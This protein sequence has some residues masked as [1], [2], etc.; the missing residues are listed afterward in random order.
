MTRSFV[1][2]VAVIGG[3]ALPA[4]AD[5]VAGMDKDGK[6]T[7]P[8]V[9]LELHASILSDAVDKALLSGAWGY[10]L[11][12][13]YRWGSWGLFGQFEHNFWLTTEQNVDVVM[14]AFNLG[15]GLELTYARGFVRTSL[16]LGPSILGFDSALDDAGTTGFFFELRPVGLRWDVHKHVVMGLDPI[17]FALVA[18]VLGGIPILEVQYRTTLYVEGLF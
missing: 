9:Q 10:G 5:E 11:K 12:G 14:G 1:L 17:S 4:A 16:A 15:I 18:P 3:M 13:G 7:G 8:F 6:I 2:V